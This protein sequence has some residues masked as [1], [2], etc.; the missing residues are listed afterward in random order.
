VCSRLSTGRDLFFHVSEFCLVGA[1]FRPT[2]LASVVAF[3][4][5]V[6]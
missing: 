6:F 1:D 5:G 4:K 3:G 2:L